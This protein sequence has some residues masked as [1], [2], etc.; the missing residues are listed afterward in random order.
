MDSNCVKYLPNPTTIEQLWV[1][2]SNTNFCYV[3]C[4]KDICYECYQIELGWSI[5]QLYV[6]QDK[7]DW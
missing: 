3:Q 4:A 2:N 7:E 1:R 6:E 5:F